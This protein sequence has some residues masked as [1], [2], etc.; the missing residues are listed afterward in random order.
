M[1]SVKRDLR[2]GG[3]LV[4]TLDKPP[5]NAIDETLLRDLSAAVKG[6]AA[7][8]SV[9][10]VVLT[11]TGRFFSSGFDFS[12]PRR[13]DAVALELYELYRSCHL[14]LLT[15]P[16]PTVAMVNGHAVAG[17]LVLVL[18]CDVRIGRK[19]S[20]RLGFTEIAVGASFPRAAFEIV[21]LRL[22]H[23]ST[24][25]LLLGAEIYDAAEGARLGVFDALVAPEDLEQAAVQRALHL[26]RH[27][28]EAYAF[29]KAQIVGDAAARIRAETPDE[30]LSTMLVWITEES[31]AA[32]R[33]KRE[34]LG[35]S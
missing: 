4:L 17:G 31:R 22:T 11:G 28:R 6:A 5:A 19:A 27:P 8:D 10:A 32:R 18:A 7:D 34:Q 1:S 30:A 16:K 35:M 12:V 3:V 29:T 24:S 26:G 14:D 13:E 9:R 21:R 2:D 23:A 33:R 20:D 15:L 25:E